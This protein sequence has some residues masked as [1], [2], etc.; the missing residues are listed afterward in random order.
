MTFWTPFQQRYFSGIVQGNYL[1]QLCVPGIIAMMAQ[2]DR[3]INILITVIGNLP[4]FRLKCAWDECVYGAGS[5]AKNVVF[6]PFFLT[7][8]F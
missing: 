6:A 8:F 7:F 1:S 5:D 2:S 3:G 4:S